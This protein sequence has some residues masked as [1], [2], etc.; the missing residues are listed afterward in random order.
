MVTTNTAK[1]KIKLWFKKNKREEYIVLGREILERELSKA[2]FDE[3]QKMDEFN[4]I[5]KELNYI[6]QEDLFAGL[7]YREISAHKVINKIKKLEKEE[8]IIAKPTKS[9]AGTKDII[10]LEGMLYHI[11]KCCMPI[12]GEPIVGAVTR[13][14]GVSV[15]RIDCPT[16]ND[17]PSERLM[18][19]SWANV[20]SKKVY[21]VPIR[22]ETEDKV[23][24]FQ[25]V[26]GKVTDNKTNIAYASGFSKHN[27][28]GI[29][30][31]G[32]EVR[33]IDAL[34]KIINSIQSL[35]EVISVKRTHASQNMKRSHR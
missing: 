27:K 20:E 2:H 13:S 8:D 33:D 25:Q 9:K 34:T 19:I 32:L 17:I 31:L 11:S 12:P 4:R 1:S 21:V 6:S 22:I 26:L 10:G 3:Y 28:I 30:E 29:I 24:V 14:R 7:G 18:P 15:H 23:G 16:L 35:P 5:A